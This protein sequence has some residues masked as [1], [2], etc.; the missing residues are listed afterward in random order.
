MFII[1]FRYIVADLLKEKNISGNRLF[2][3]NI[4]IFCFQI[5]QS[6]VDILWQ[7]WVSNVLT[8]YF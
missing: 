8:M 1:L 4:V 3:M 7:L 2:G 5:F 6:T